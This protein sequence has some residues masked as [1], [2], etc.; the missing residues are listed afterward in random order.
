MAQ[1]FISIDN[2]QVRLS[3]QYVRFMPTCTTDQEIGEVRPKQN[4]LSFANGLT[5]S[6]IGSGV[7]V[8][9]EK[10]CKIR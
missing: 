4:N 10:R 8:S 9:K 6:Y 5:N 7:D 1:L 2:A 3:D